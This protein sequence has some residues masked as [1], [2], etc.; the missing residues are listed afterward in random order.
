[1]AIGSLGLGVACGRRQVLDVRGSSLSWPRRSV[2]QGA[3]YWTPVAVGS[4]NLVLQ[5]LA[6]LVNHLLQP[7]WETIAQSI[8]IVLGVDMVLTLFEQ[9]A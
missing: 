3:R 1:M 8:D 4:S 9:L 7:R 6:L 2:W 5:Q